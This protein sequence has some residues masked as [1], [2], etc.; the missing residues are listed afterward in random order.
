M[1]AV[2]MRAEMLQIG[3]LTVLN[4]CYNA[5]PASMKNALAMLR[6]LRSAVTRES[7][8]PLVFICGEM[9]ELGPQTESLHAELGVAAAEAGVDLLVAVGAAPRPPPRR[10][11]RGRDTICRHCASTTPPASAIMC[12]NF[13]ERTI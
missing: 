10:R 13:S 6:N 2:S 9:A 11:G 3:G 12:R 1:A 8:P 5:N 7:R 4:D